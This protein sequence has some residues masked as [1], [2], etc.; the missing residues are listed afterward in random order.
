MKGERMFSEQIKTS[1]NG[2]E[3]YTLQNSVDMI[4]PYITGSGYKTIWCPF[5]KAES[6][7]VKTF[8]KLGFSVNYGHIETGQDFFEYQEPQG[9][10][11]VSNPPFSKRDMILKRLYEWDIPFA[12]IIN[13]NGLFDS[14]KRVDIF[15]EHKVE[16]LIPKGRMRFKQKDKGELN[17]P[18]FQSIYVCNRLLGEQIVFDNTNF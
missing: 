10:I 13:F 1:V 16:M 3:Y 2:D 18:N 6:N 4:V 5:D 9:E 15:K 11:V 14:K 12:L 17:S 8:Q 7:F